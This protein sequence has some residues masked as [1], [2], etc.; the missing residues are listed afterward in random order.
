MRWISARAAFALLILA[1]LNAPTFAETRVALV[2][3][4]SAYKNAPAL[5]NPRNDAE[6]MAAALKRLGFD[7]SLGVDLEKQAMERL[8]QGFV[9]KLDRADVALLFYAGHGLQVSGSNYLIPIDAKL[10]RETDLAFQTISLD[11]VQ[12]LMEQSQRVNIMVLDA[13]RDNPLAR[14]LA[15]NMGTRSVGIGRGLGQAQAG[16][17]T[18]IV[19]A[20]QP[21]NVA[22]DGEGQHSPFTAA[23]LAN[24]ETQGLEVRQV[25]TRVRQAVIQSTKGKQVPWDSSSLTGDW[26]FTAAPG[27][28]APTPQG[29][30]A[31]TPPPQAPPAPAPADRSADSENL[32]WQS[33]RDSRNAADYKAYL[34]KYPNGTFAELAKIRLAEIE[35][36]AQT[37]PPAPPV[38]EKP[39][40][41]A[42]PVRVS[43]WEPGMA[44]YLG[45]GQWIDESPAATA[46]ACRA[47]CLANPR[48][49]VWFS[50]SPNNDGTRSCVLGS[51]VKSRIT[52]DGYI[53]GYIRTTT[54]AAP[55]ATPA[56]AAK[57][58]A[59]GP[60][61][62]STARQEY[63]RPGTVKFLGGYDLFSGG[64]KHCT[65]FG[66]G[67]VRA[68]V[69]GAYLRWDVPFT[70]GAS[71]CSCLIKAR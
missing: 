55:G 37:P 25:F 56:P 27:A 58:P 18:L 61:N 59:I 1:C 54:A 46:Q 5:P 7:V 32:F 38:P 69:E 63:C 33:I 21:G 2:I 66:Y 4:N 39:A 3:G 68:W 8:L 22:L 65:D 52:L 57:A 17:G 53:G 36:A 28:T 60:I 23:L 19:Y 44:V 9:E 47:R 10:D 51:G 41:P 71:R 67:I 11:L 26:F 24:L 31:A 64:V 13:C 34:A 40:R 16:I 35:K 42:A 20:T 48:C 43:T 62:A 70:D 15:R 29:P 49:T 14:N 50:R 12:R 30:A 45:D 6:G